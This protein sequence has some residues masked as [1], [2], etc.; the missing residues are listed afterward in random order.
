M[1]CHPTPSARS[2][3]AAPA[4]CTDRA[5]C[6]D[7]CRSAC[8]S[9]RRSVAAIAA[10]TRFGRET[11]HDL[12]KLVLVV[13]REVEAAR[14]GLAQH[15]I[16]RRLAG[17][18]GGAEIGAEDDDRLPAKRVAAFPCGARI[19]IGPVHIGEHDL[20]PVDPGDVA[21]EHLPRRLRS[22]LD[23]LRHEHLVAGVAQ[24]VGEAG[25]EVAFG[26]R[27]QRPGEIGLRQGR[28][29]PFPQVCSVG[30]ESRRRRKYFAI[31]R[32]IPRRADLRREPCAAAFSACPGSHGSLYLDRST[33]WVIQL[34]VHRTGGIW[35]SGD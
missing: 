4:G 8:V 11:F 19:R 34:D 22:L 33:W 18:F 14:R 29:A 7:L 12:G 31:W 17:F 20:A 9:S 23:L 24:L 16:E 10:A 32:A 15:Q 35:L 27:E 13:C 6:Y 30:A 28:S 25:V 21:L 1:R 2:A 3:P 26:H 5:R